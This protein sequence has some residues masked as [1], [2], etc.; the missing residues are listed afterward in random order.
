M[1]GLSEKEKRIKKLSKKK[2]T[3]EINYNAPLGDLEGFFEKQAKSVNEYCGE[4]IIKIKKG[5]K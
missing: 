1:F 2:G 4:E 5:K 3:Y